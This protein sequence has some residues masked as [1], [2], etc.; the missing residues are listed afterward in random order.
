MR[1]PRRIGAGGLGA[2]FGPADTVVQGLSLESLERLDPHARIHEDV[3][4][5]GGANDRRLGRHYGRGHQEPEYR[6]NDRGRT[7]KC[8]MLHDSLL[9]SQKAIHCRALC[10]ASL[11][12]SA[13]AAAGVLVR[14]V[15]AGMGREILRSRC[16]CT[17]VA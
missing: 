8:L 9:Y 15:E 3:V 16:G 10:A 1:C 11:M 5:L 7:S 12:T 6:S 17:G 4:Y 13:R 14:V 2:D